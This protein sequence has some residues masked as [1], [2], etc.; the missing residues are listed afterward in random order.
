MLRV[1]LDTNIYG[2][3]LEEPDAEEIEKRI[4]EEKEFVVYN[5]PIIRKEIRNIP[6]LTDASRKARISLL[7]MYDRITGGHYLRHSIEI[8]L[9]AKKYFDHYRNLGGNLGHTLLNYKPP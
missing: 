6:K 4:R 2:N 3:L 5:F 8:M 1:V 7:E 9:L